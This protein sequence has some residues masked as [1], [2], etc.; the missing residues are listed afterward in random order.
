MSRIAS[1]ASYQPVVIIR[2]KMAGRF[3]GEDRRYVRVGSITD[4]D[5]AKRLL[6]DCDAVVNLAYAGKSPEALANNMK[7]VK[8]LA[9]FGTAETIINMSTVAVHASPFCA[10]HMDF[11]RPRPDS[12]YG[13]SKLAMEGI[14]SRALKNT[15]TH[16]FLLRLGPVY[17]AGQ[18]ASKMVF[19]DVRTPG[20][21]LPFDGRLT[22]NAVS[23]NRFTDGIV[24]LLSDPPA[25]G[26]YNFTEEPQ[27]T[28]REI[29]DLHTEAWNLPPVPSLSNQESVSLRS[30][31]LREAG[32]ESVPLS[33]KLRRSVG[34]IVRNP[35]VNNGLSKRLYLRYRKHVPPNIDKKIA[36]ALGKTSADLIVA[37]V[38]ESEPVRPKPSWLL[39][40]DPIP[41][42]NVPKTALPNAY[43]SDL[44]PGLLS[45]REDL[46][47]FRWDTNALYR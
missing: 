41:G 37:A 18:T 10:E 14:I 33:K 36:G 35:A 23:I 44:S 25:N 24:S 1:E 27:R 34:F 7:L 45:W 15:G 22:S 5:S 43:D 29:Y 47:T 40:S 12:P 19:K 16:Y 21:A 38:A 3:L 2:D 13:E 28:W 20:F 31:Y 17:G 11:V 42:R 39:V 9:S 26:V 4:R 46:T 32:F 8:A 30:G 6:G